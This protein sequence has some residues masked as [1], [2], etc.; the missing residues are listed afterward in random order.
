MLTG[1]HIFPAPI[2]IVLVAPA[3]LLLRPPSRPPEGGAPPS[4]S[5]K[6]KKNGA[7]SLSLVGLQPRVL[8]RSPQAPFFLLWGCRFPP[9]L[10]LAATRQSIHSL[11]S[12]LSLASLVQFASLAIQNHSLRSLFTLASLVCRSPCGLSL[13][14]LRSLILDF[15]A[16][17]PLHPKFMIPPKTHN[18]LSQQKLNI[19]NKNN[20]KNTHFVK[21]NDTTPHLLRIFSVPC[22]IFGRSNPFIYLCRCFK[23]CPDLRGLSTA[24]RQ[25]P[26][27]LD[28]KGG[29]RRRGDDPCGTSP[30]PKQKSVHSN[31]IK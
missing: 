18:K 22:P 26:R 23:E 7:L 31:I 4:V 9:L 28:T 24:G 8:L 20:P 29:C 17:R 30:N 3:G 11:R 19:A 14:S 16:S 12:L 25:S 5:P 2:C 27:S 13:R 15:A 6:T 1:K 10:D 21:I